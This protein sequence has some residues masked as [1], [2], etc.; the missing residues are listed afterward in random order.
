MVFCYSTGG[1]CRSAGFD[2]CVEVR[3]SSVITQ[4]SVPV[5]RGRNGS[6]LLLNIFRHP[7]LEFSQTGPLSAQVR[8]CAVSVAEQEIRRSGVQTFQ[9]CIGF[10]ERAFWTH[11]LPPLGSDSP[12]LTVREII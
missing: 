6:K 7:T 1:L 8:A 9:R 4:P 2:F 3:T 5:R 10:P 11:A 12:P